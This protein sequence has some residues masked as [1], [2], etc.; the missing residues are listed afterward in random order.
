[1]EQG[2]HRTLLREGAPQEEVGAGVST[3]DGVRR[4]RMRAGGMARERSRRLRL[5]AE[6]E[7]MCRGWARERATERATERARLGSPEVDFVLLRMCFFASVWEAVRELDKWLRD[8]RDLPEKAPVV[9][10]LRTRLV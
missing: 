2:A 6:G 9:L 5:S 10:G 8:G 4:K 3:A 7:I 1:M